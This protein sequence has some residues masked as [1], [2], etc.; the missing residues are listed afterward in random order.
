MKKIAIIGMLSLCAAGAYAQGTLIFGDFGFE[1]YYSQ[2]YSPN[3]ANTTVETYGNTAA[4]NPVGTQTYPSAQYTLIGGSTGTGQ[5]FAYGNQFS[6]QI[7]W[8]PNT[9]I[10]SHLTAGSTFLPAIMATIETPQAAYSS[11]N[12]TSDVGQGNGNPSPSYIGTMV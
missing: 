10:A 9:Y 4:Q 11:F 8:T 7:Y 3:T 12:G 5:N 6:V 2:I 1:G